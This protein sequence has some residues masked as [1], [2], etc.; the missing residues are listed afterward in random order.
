MTTTLT[1]K[2]KHKKAIQRNFYNK[3]ME[4]ILN[5]KELF[6]NHSFG[7]KIWMLV[8]MELWQR[9]YIDKN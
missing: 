3:N 6:T 7:I 2:D 1:Q 9:E 8:N 4:K 5:N